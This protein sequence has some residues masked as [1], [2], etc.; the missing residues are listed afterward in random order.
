MLYSSLGAETTCLASTSPTRTLSTTISPQPNKSNRTSNTQ[1]DHSHWSA[2]TGEAEQYQASIL[3]GSSRA[4]RSSWEKCPSTERTGMHQDEVHCYESEPYSQM[5]ILS[6]RDKCLLYAR[7][8]LSQI[9]FVIG[10]SSA[11]VN[12][13]RGILRSRNKHGWSID[14]WD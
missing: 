4:A 6:L 10:Q 1:Y 12:Q 5:V 7:R 2:N 9:C 14:S 11:M 3:W 13:D 8:I